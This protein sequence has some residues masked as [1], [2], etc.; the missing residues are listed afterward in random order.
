MLQIIITNFVKNNKNIFRRFSID[1]K[2]FT[3]QENI[4]KTNTNTNVNT[5][6]QIKLKYSI[7]FFVI[8]DCVEAFTFSESKDITKSTGLGWSTLVVFIVFIL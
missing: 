8:R 6:M 3:T 7:G 4:I 2:N 1:K 5:D